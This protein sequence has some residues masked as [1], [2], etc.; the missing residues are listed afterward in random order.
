MSAEGTT[1]QNP[2]TWHLGLAAAGVINAGLFWVAFGNVLGED[3]PG[4]P[5]AFWFGV[6]VAGYFVIRG[7]RSIVAALALPVLFGVAEWIATVIA[8]VVEGVVYLPP[9]AGW[10]APIS[11][12]YLPAHGMT[13][14]VAG[15]AGRAMAAATVFLF[16]A[17]ADRKRT[18]PS[19]L[20]C[21]FAGGVLGALGF[22]LGWFTQSGTPTQAWAFAV[23][24]LVWQTGMGLVMGLAWPAEEAE[25]NTLAL[26]P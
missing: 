2:R 13:M 18:L 22:R 5:N 11:D 21:S 12:P 7:R 26:A 15:A 25:T 4:T 23:L 19:I 8:I 17:A 20:I 9:G 16:H 1:R 6:L 14:F 10:G 24:Y 3:I